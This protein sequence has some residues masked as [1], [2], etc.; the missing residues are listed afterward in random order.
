M[1]NELATINVTA[2]I[3][4]EGTFNTVDMST[5]DGAM[6]V[7]NAINNSQ[8]LSEY[9]ESFEE[10]PV[11][12][13][14]DIVVTPGI[15]KARERNQEDTPCEDTRLILADGISLMTQSSGIARSARF[16]AGLCGS[17]LHGGILIR[18]VEQKLRN[19]NTIK[20]LEIVGKAE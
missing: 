9:V 5:F 10:N 2:N 17:E 16:I 11:L 20:N 15:R 6:K 4:P 12:N 13:V 7:T 3:I 19:G 14:V 8:S 1:T 18:V